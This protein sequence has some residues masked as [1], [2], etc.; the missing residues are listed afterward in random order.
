MLVLVAST[1]DIFLEDLAKADSPGDA[2]C[3]PKTTGYW[4][5]G[6]PVHAI[7]AKEEHWKADIVLQGR[8]KETCRFQSILMIVAQPQAWTPAHSGV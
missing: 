3:N 7:F 2:K 6:Q 4:T 1:S 8:I 5:T